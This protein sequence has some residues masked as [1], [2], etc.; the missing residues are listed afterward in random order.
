M[1]LTEYQK[2]QIIS[3]VMTIQEIVKSEGLN[4]EYVSEE[5]ADV[6]LPLFLK[7][8]NI[9]LEEQI[10]SIKDIVNQIHKDLTEVK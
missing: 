2:M 8:A 7:Y 10:L 4:V 9:P 5:Q 3:M 6:F 1:E